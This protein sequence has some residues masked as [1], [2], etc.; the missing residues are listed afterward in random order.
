[1][2][3]TSR[4]VIVVALGNVSCAL[5]RGGAAAALRALRLLRPFR[6]RP[7]FA[8]PSLDGAATRVLCR[9]FHINQMEKRGGTSTRPPFTILTD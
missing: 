7:A 3:A 2:P 1:M 6:D 5:G 4:A 9:I 8:F